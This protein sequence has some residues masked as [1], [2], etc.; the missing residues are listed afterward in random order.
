MI[1]SEHK[2]ERCYRSNIISIALSGTRCLLVFLSYPLVYLRDQV[3][4]V[5]I[6]E[7][8]L[9]HPQEWDQGLCETARRTPSPMKIPPVSQRRNFAA[10]KRCLSHFPR[11]L[12]RKATLESTASPVT[13][14]TRPRTRS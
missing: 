5:Q 1:S 12:V 11:K 13:L 10:P 9:A 2:A 6:C 3:V 4:H 8:A 14:Y 7:A